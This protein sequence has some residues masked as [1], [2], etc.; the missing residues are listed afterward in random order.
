MSVNNSHTIGSSNNNILTTQVGST[1][2]G[3]GLNIDLDNLLG[4]KSKQTGAVMSM[5][6]LASNSPTHQ[7]PRSFGK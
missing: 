5:N 7:A 1:W 3:A 2:A 4:N 6:Q